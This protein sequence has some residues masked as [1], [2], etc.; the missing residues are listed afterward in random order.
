MSDQNLPLTPDELKALRT[1]LHEVIDRYRRPE[2][3]GDEIV[4]AQI[5]GFPRKR[6]P[7]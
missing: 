2:R 5:Q 3:Q 4:V 7:E 1:E 6:R